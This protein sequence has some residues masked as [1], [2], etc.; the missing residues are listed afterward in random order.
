MRRV[1]LDKPEQRLS[2]QSVNGFED[3]VFEAKAKAIEFCPRAV[4]EFEA[5]PRGHHLCCYSMYRR[6]N[7]AG[8][9]KV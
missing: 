3:R 8:C 1:K 6:S 2:L 9:R 4:L 7:L 5:S